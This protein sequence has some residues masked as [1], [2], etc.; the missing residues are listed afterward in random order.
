VAS[1]AYEDVSLFQAGAS[2]IDTGGIDDHNAFAAN[3][4]LNDADIASARPEAITDPP[5]I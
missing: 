5:L 4:G 3:L 2:I 1:N